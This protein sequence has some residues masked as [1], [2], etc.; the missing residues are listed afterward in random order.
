MTTIKTPIKR[1]TAAS[2]RIVELV[3]HVG[4]RLYEQAAEEHGE[5]RSQGERA[6]LE[7]QRRPEEHGHSR[8]CEAEWPGKA[9]PLFEGLPSS[10][11][12]RSANCGE[13]PQLLQS[14]AAS[15]LWFRASALR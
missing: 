11:V 9:E 5:K 12:H 8:R 3:E 7:R 1:N 15:G 13:S 10:R 14:F 6:V 4:G 2:L